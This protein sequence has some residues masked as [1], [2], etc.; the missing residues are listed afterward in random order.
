MFEKLKHAFAVDT[1][2]HPPTPAERELVERV[3]QE[4]V[5]RQMTAPAL[6]A[7]EMSRPLNYLGA[8]A[9]HFCAP[10]AS[11]FVDAAEYQRFA[12]FLERRDAMEL[13]AQRIETLEAHS[14]TT[15]QP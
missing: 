7:L 3:A 13:L 9:L 6:A 15:G 14:K 8:Q 5:R 2:P 1:H 4:I 12:R 10:I 11:L